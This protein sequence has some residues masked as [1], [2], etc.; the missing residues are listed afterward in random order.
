[1]L[2]VGL[3]VTALLYVV[4]ALPAMDARWLLI[5]GIGVVLFGVAA[6]LGRVTPWWLALGWAGHVAW[7]VALHLDRAQPVVGEWYPLFCVGF[8][9]PVAGYIWRSVQRD[10]VS[11]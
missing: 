3:F 6:W 1:M 2:A 5:E 8:D 4:L 11:A 9:L 7:D 10:A